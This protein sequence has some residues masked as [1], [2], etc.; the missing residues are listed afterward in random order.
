MKARSIRPAFLFF[1][2]QLQV[3]AALRLSDCTA[4]E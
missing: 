3:L 1:G 2:E 4:V